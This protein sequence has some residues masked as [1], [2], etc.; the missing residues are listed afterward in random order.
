MQP[1]K[2]ASV[3]EIQ[4][5]LLRLQE[6]TK[7]RKAP[8]PPTPLQGVKKRPQSG[9]EAEAVTGLVSLLEQASPPAEARVVPA[10][11]YPLYSYY[12]HTMNCLNPY[13]VVTRVS[14]Q[15]ASLNVRIC[16]YITARRQPTS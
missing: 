9:V 5:D 12:Y 2:A 4:A 1:D 8:Q 10:T 15:N 11:A 6:P 3:S 13:S 16:Y 14:N 7:K